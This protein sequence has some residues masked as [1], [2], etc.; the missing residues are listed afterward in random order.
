[1][2]WKNV[3]NLKRKWMKKFSILRK[4][5]QKYWKISKSRYMVSQISNPC[6][7]NQ[8]GQRYQQMQDS[9]PSLD[10]LIY[11]ATFSNKKLQK[12]LSLTI[13]LMK[14]IISDIIDDFNEKVIE[15]LVIPD[16]NDDSKAT[17]N[18]HSQADRVEEYNNL[19]QQQ[20]MK[21]KVQQNEIMNVNQ[22]AQKLVDNLIQ[23]LKVEQKEQ[24]LKYVVT[25]KHIKH[26][27]QQFGIE[28]FLQDNK[29]IF[30]DLILHLILVQEEE[31][32][33]IFINRQQSLKTNLKIVR[34]RISKFL[35]RN[36]KQLKMT[37]YHQ[38]T[39]KRQGRVAII[40]QQL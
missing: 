39:F 7:K 37:K 40:N 10:I 16:I 2:V 15:Y 33:L 8:L 30:G 28:L 20:K 24:Y 22:S 5:C 14:K 34:S 4:R 26:L 32:K 29:S 18:E 17:H 13:L 6:S 1:M 35:R 36:V 25:I 19:K 12:N 27:K 3:K 38:S 31:L 21:Q 23:Q 11:Y 9:N